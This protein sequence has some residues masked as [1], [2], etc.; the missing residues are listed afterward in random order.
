MSRICNPEHK[1]W[2][3]M[4]DIPSFKII[5]SDE[6]EQVYDIVVETGASKFLVDAE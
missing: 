6:V 1:F 5:P 3:E 4:R 2:E